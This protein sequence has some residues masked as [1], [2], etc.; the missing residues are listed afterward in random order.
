ME[1]S[2]GIRSGKEGTGEAIREKGTRCK[3]KLRRQ[4]FENRQQAGGT[5]QG[6][7]FFRGKIKARGWPKLQPTR[8]LV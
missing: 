7:I 1:K 3:W 2:G 6:P 5:L 8:A 4:R